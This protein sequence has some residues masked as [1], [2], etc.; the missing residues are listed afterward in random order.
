MITF[1][2]TPH[3]CLICAAPFQIRQAGC[4]I[5]SLD[6][7]CD[8]CVAKLWNGDSKILDEMGATYSKRIQ[9]IESALPPE[10]GPKRQAM[11]REIIALLETL[12]HLM[13]GEDRQEIMSDLMREVAEFKRKNLQL[14]RFLRERRS[15]NPFAENR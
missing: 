3:Q 5:D 2:L 10:V 13:Q 12:S 15:A 6:S 7:L 4:C 9:E 14:D 1:D 11:R 8:G